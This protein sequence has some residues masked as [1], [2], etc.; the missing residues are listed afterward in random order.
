MSSV[1][2]QTDQSSPVQQ[3]AGTVLVT[4]D[5]ATQMEVRE[6]GGQH[7]THLSDRGRRGASCRRAGGL[8]NPVG[9]REC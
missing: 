4:R 9:A 3:T 6:V 7:G 2:V 5:L 1:E 8:P